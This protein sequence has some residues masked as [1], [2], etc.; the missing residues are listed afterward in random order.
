MQLIPDLDGG[1]HILNPRTGELSSYSTE[2][3]LLSQESIPL[4]RKGGDYAGII[5]VLFL[6]DGYR[7]SEIGYFNADR[8]LRSLETTLT[9]VNTRLTRSIPLEA[10]IGGFY[11]IDAHPLSDVLMEYERT[12]RS[13]VARSYRVSDILSE[14]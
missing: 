2:G 12:G 3:A 8:S 11:E 10:R 6:R 14:K 4:D 13:I 5:R 7:I 1:M 9:Q